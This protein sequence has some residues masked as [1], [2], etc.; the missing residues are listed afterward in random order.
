MIYCCN[1][2]GFTFQRR[3]EVDDCPICSKSF[4]REAT[5]E[6]KT[7]YQK[8]YSDTDNADNIHRFYIETTKNNH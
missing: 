6:E 7:E 2:C 8:T 3:G 4:I 5:V 1:S